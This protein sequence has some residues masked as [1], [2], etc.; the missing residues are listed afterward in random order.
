MVG[1]PWCR[2][3]VM[4][5]LTAVSKITG[6]HTSC[7]LSLCTVPTGPMARIMSDM[8]SGICTLL[9]AI[10]AQQNERDPCVVTVFCSEALVQVVCNK[11]RTV[12]FQRQR[13]ARRRVWLLDKRVSIPLSIDAI[14]RKFSH[15]SC[16]RST[17][18]GD[19]PPRC[20][21]R[22][23][24]TSRSLLSV[25]LSGGS[26]FTGFGRPRRQLGERSGKWVPISRG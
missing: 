13:A 17:T 25:D 18:F 2:L 12:F 19:D 1:H 16:R 4:D 6:N 5:A 9:N 3:Y 26:P 24:G 11:M 8:A 22:K 23:G 21:K 10:L 20:L 14:I 7:S 15:T